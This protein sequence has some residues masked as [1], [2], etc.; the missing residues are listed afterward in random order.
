MSLS[1]QVPLARRPHLRPAS[2]VASSSHLAA[3]PDAPPCALLVGHTY[4]ADLRRA[5]LEII[6][7]AGKAARRGSSAVARGK[8]AA[9]PHATGARAPSVELHVLILSEGAASAADDGSENSRCTFLSWLTASPGKADS[10][11]PAMILALFRAAGATVH[12][13]LLPVSSKRLS[14]TVS[15]STALASLSRALSSGSLGAALANG[16]ASCAFVHSRFDEDALRAFMGAMAEY[17]T[18]PSPDS[19]NVRTNALPSI[20]LYLP[21]HPFLSDFDLDLPSAEVPAVRIV[22]SAAEHFAAASEAKSG[23]MGHQRRKSAEPLLATG[24]DAN[25]RRSFTSPAPLAPSLDGSTAKPLL[26]RPAPGAGPQSLAMRLSIDTGVAG[27]GRDVVLRVSEAQTPTKG[28]SDGLRPLLLRPPSSSS[29][30]PRSTSPTRSIASSSGSL[31]STRPPPP[32]TNSPPKLRLEIPASPPT[33]LLVSSFSPDSD[34]PS[35]RT[36]PTSTVRFV[37]QNYS[38][39]C[40]LPRGAPNRSETTMSGGGKDGWSPVSREVQALLQL[41]VKKGER[42]AAGLRETPMAAAV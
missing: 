9:T 22:R 19:S 37:P 6:Q 30:R 5:G 7:R 4:D 14:L 41:R 27:E 18:A 38:P 20:T 13:H 23:A 25:H 3:A 17:F 24:T 26:L 29:L 36:P 32:A 2:A 15:S 28:P 40:K 34:E 39:I 10:M 42:A 21:K 11:R 33:P 35:P 16:L 31:R 12:H 1:T 8:A